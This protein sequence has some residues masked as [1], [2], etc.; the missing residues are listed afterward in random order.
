[1][2]RWN[3][4][5]ESTVAPGSV[6]RSLFDPNSIVEDDSGADSDSSSLQATLTGSSGVEQ[7]E[8]DEEQQPVVASQRLLKR[9]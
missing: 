3:N 4:G 6:W 2:I 1:M 5:R 8:E 7:T 9:Y